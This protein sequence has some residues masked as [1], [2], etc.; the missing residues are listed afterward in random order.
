MPEQFLLYFSKN[1]E[2]ILLNTF[3]IYVIF[4]ILFQLL[5]EVKP[6]I[7]NS[8]PDLR[9]GHTATIINDKLYVSR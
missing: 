1:F 3:L 9:N 6:Q 8:R 5:V 7:V 4:G 2:M